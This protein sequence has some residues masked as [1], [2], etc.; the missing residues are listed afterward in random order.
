MNAGR[1]TKTR[2]LSSEKPGN[3]A[4]MFHDPWWDK[5]LQNAVA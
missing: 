4:P 3:A 1:L 2:S 5:G